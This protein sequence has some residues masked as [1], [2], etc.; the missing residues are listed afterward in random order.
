[1]VFLRINSLLESIPPSGIRKFFD[2]ASSMKDVVSL[3]IGEPDFVTPWH[4]RE[5]CMY[6]LEKGHT[7]YTSNKGLL[8][9]RHEVARHVARKWG[10]RYDAENEVL[11]GV[12]VS[13]LID[14]ALRTLVNP[15]DEVVIPEPCYV[16]YKP[17]ALL[18]GAVV[19]VVETRPENGF[20]L[21]GKELE[22]AVSE[23]TRALVL[24]Y[25]NNPT[26]AI[27]PKKRLEEVAGVAREHGLA[28]VSDEIYAD[29]TYD[30]THC[31]IA[32]LKGM[33]EKTVLLNG[34]S[35]AYAMTGF[36]L[37]YACGPEKIIAGM[38]KIHQ[39]SVLCAPTPAQRA[40]VEALKNGEKAVEEM[41]GEYDERRRFIV[42]GL[43]EIGLDCFEPKGAFY[44]FPSV[45]RTRLSSTEFAEKLLAEERVAVVPGN[46]FGQCGE[47]FVRCSYASSLENIQEALSRMERFVRKHLKRFR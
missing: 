41:R 39:Y 23:K 19:K 35:K 7:H 36:R 44:A 17:L 15:G 27:M 34:F 21:T 47:G 18:A 46:A 22:A 1:M 29:L 42:K 30:G 26:G 31:S 38:T 6:A 33:R 4:V 43:N 32:S 45:R 5:A 14:L 37:G 2:L 3:G 8:E 13:E 25:P 28:I 24:S 20:Q 40:A 9:L 10:P 11:I 16:S 12:G